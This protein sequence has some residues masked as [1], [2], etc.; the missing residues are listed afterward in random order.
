MSGDGILGLVATVGD[1]LVYAEEC[2]IDR[3]IL[4]DSECQHSEQNREYSP[5]CSVTLGTVEQPQQQRREKAVL[6]HVVR[7]S[8]DKRGIQRIR[9][10]E[11][12]TECGRELASAGDEVERDN[13]RAD[14]YCLQY[15]ERQRRAENK[16]EGQH[17]IV[18]R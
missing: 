2:N 6:V 16:V 12:G 14:D 8:A 5:F 10:A 1:E 4:L 7:A 17:Q 9:K 15:L 11:R 18:Y 3:C 13:A